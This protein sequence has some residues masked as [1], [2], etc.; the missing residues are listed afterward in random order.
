MKTLVTYENLK[1]GSKVLGLA[2]MLLMLVTFGYTQSQ[3][4]SNDQ[5]STSSSPPSAL[6]PIL[7]TGSGK[8]VLPLSL[9]S[10][11][12]ST[13][14][15]YSCGWLRCFHCWDSRIDSN[16][17][18]FAAVSEYTSLPNQRF[19]GAAHMTIHNIIPYNGYVEVLIDT[20]WT[21]Y[22]I[23]IRLDLLVDP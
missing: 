2:L 22:P 3:N 21:A 4:P 17:R 11:S 10:G 12:F 7:P 5:A 20:G 19:L 8:D 14:C 15:T 23:N 6:K 1:P 13:Y 18:V 9:G 16:A